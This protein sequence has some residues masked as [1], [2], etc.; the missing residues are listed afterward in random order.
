MVFDRDQSHVKFLRQS[1][2]VVVTP[3]QYAVNWPFEMNEWMWNSFVRHQSLLQENAHLRAEQLLLKA[4]MQ[5]ILTLEKEN[6]Q[7]RALLQSGPRANGKM[8]VGQILLVAKKPFSQQITLNKG[9]YHNVFVGQPVLDATGVMGQVIQVTPL[10]SQVLLITD[11]RS[12]LPVQDSRSGIRAI[13]NGKGSIG[14]LE[15]VNVP[16]TTDIKVGDVL[17][18]S[19]LGQR[20]PVG[21]PV[22]IVTKMSRRSGNEFTQIEVKPTAHL[23]RSRLVLLLWPEASTKKEH[24]GE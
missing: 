9:S 23:T 5:Q 15:L 3:L 2:A 11:R 7:L 12:A 8:I 13:A 18:A 20:F 16:L 4:R 19:G 1:I 6:R 22:G 17:V 10:T 14:T 21:Y 24:H